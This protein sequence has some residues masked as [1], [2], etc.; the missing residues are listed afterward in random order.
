MGW[1]LAQVAN[2]RVCFC[3]C[4]NSS[5]DLQCVKFVSAGFCIAKRKRN[6][7]ENGPLYVPGCSCRPA[8]PLWRAE[9]VQKPSQAPLLRLPCCARDVCH[10][11]YSVVQ[12]GLQKPLQHL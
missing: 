12:V 9:P 5:V 3:I 7:E 2:C 4:S 11:S 6:M 8:E 10:L 1:L